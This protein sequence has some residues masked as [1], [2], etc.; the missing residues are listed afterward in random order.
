MAA[1]SGIRPRTP[2]GVSVTLPAEDTATVDTATVGDAGVIR[3][4]PR[5]NDYHAALFDSPP[6]SNTSGA[7]S[8]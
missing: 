8:R 6:T 1:R 5:D 3:D 2:R 4:M 7:F